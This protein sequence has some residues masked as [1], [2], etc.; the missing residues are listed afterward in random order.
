MSGDI[1]WALEMWLF[2][3]LMFRMVK[4]MYI[5]EKWKLYII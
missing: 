2:M 5:V 1:S 4:F 3:I